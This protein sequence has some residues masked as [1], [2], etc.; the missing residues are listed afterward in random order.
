MMV[1][2]FPLHAEYLKQ[3]IDTFDH[4]KF[5]NDPLP[6]DPDEVYDI[7]KFVN[8]NDIWNDAKGILH[9]NHFYAIGVVGTQGTGKT[10]LA[11][12]F[13]QKALDNDYK[14]IY[15]LPEDYLSNVNVWLEKV[16]VDPR[17]RN[18]LVLD[19]LSYS[20]DTQ[21]KKQQALMKNVVSRFRHIFEGEVFVIYITH[22]LHATPPML[23][24]AGTWIFTQL[25]TIDRD[26]MREIIGKSKEQRDTLEAMQ[27]FLT[28]AVTAG[29]KNADITYSINEKL[30]KFKWGN[31]NDKG[32]GRLMAALHNNELQ[33]FNAVADSDLDF[34]KYQYPNVDP[35][36]EQ[37]VHNQL[38]E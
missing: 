16:S 21:S 2:N 32:D 3:V 12:Q 17:A 9:N 18:C 33:I 19:D 22:R 34:F 26:D 10:T 13:A 7:Q 36:L 38:T 4:K 20:F 27:S 28:N 37:G 30:Y 15:A 8:V 24:N 6:V 11:E 25:S 31:A 14:L 5:Y 23:R 35:I 1:N 29:N